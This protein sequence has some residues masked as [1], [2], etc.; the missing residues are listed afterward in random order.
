MK[1][2]FRSTGFKLLVALIFV[3]FCLMLA[4]SNT[5]NSLTANLF[6]SVATPMQRISTIVTNNAA[7]V[8]GSGKTKE[9]LE[10]ENEQLRA[11]VDAL[12]KKL[13]N[14]YTYQQEN[15]QLRK[16]LE[17]KNENPDFKPITAAVVGRDPNNLFGEFTIDQGTR[18][19]VSLN[20]PVVTDA[21]VVGWVS[22]VSNS[23]SRVTTFLS[24]STQIS[25]MDKVT[26]ETGVIG[27]DIKSAD[28]NILKLRYLS[29]DTKVAAGDI[30]V[31][32]GIGGVYPRNLVIGTVKSVKRSDVDV[33]LYAEVEPAVNVKEVR[34]VLVITS[35]AGQGEAMKAA[36][37]SASSSLPASSGGK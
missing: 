16:F 11:E 10:A 8:T 3:M 24:P 2:V 34:D 25:A 32:S 26:R 12:R 5:P 14:Y 1:D 33:S 23:Y 19:G 17:L 37:S 6:G 4:T 31:T 36:N 20:D 13:V 30:V 22:A 15:S 18:S 21:G 29:S 28:A 27:C 9:Q 7:A 35:F